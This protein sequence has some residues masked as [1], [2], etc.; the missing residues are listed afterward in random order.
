[1]NSDF[2]ILKMLMNIN[3]LSPIAIMKG[4]LP[5][6]IARKEKSML[7][8]ITSVAGQI[9]VPFRSFYAC[10]KFALDGFNKALDAEVTQ[11]GIHI[12]NVY[13][14]YVKTNIAR[15]AL[16]GDGVPMGVQDKRIENGIPV[17]IAVADLMKAVY[18][19]KSWISLERGTDITRKARTQLLY[20]QWHNLK[21]MCADYQS[22]VAEKKKALAKMAAKEAEATKDK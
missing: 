1:M 4:F 3:A 19:R 16:K 22:K 15:T 14:A 17:Q 18:A 10:S 20:G 13:P 9:G 7:I 8:N 21:I 12:C 11:H 2:K 5:Q 6:L